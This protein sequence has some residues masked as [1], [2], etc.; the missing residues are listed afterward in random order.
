MLGAMRL[1]VICQVTGLRVKLVL[2]PLPLA[3]AILPFLKK[4]NLL[5]AFPP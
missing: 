1:R 3:A 4:E 2:L 5:F